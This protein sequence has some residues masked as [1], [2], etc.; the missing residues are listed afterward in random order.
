MSNFPIHR[1]L[2]ITVKEEILP[3]DFPR[4]LRRRCGASSVVGANFALRFGFALC[5]ALARVAIIQT[6]TYVV[7]SRGHRESSSTERMASTDRRSLCQSNRQGQRCDC[8]RDMQTSAY[9]VPRVGQSHRSVTVDG[10]SIHSGFRAS[11][12]V[13]AG[14]GIS[15]GANAPAATTI[16]PGS[17]SMVQNRVVPHFGQKWNSICP[18]L[19]PVRE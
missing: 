5:A 6:T 8:R 12:T 14:S 18:P 1:T 13:L 4:T 16:E 2:P 3:R 19:S 10:T 11:Y 15:S 9:A 7:G 17:L